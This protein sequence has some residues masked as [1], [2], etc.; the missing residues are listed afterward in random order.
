VLTVASSAMGLGA[1]Q[2]IDSFDGD[3]ITVDDVHDPVRA[4]PQPV[5]PAPV[6]SLRRVRVVGQTDDG[7]ADGA[8]AILISQVT[9]R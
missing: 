6:E 5:V 3:H 8:H 1:N 4:D 2:A 7:C 9:A